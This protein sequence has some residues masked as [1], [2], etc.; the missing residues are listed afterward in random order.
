MRVNQIPIQM[1]CLVIRDDIHEIQRLE[2]SISDSSQSEWSKNI[3]GMASIEDDNLKINAENKNKVGDNLFYI[4]SMD[5]GGRSTI[6]VFQVKI[7]NVND[8][9][10]VVREDAMITGNQQWKEIIELEESGE[11]LYFDPSSIFSDEDPDDRMS[12]QLTST[13][14]N[15]INLTDDGILEGV[16][17]N[18]DVG[19]H[20]LTWRAT[21]KFGKSAY[22][23]LQLNVANINRS[24]RNTEHI[25]EIISTEDDYT[26]VDLNQLFFDED[27]IHG[28]S[29]DYLLRVYDSDKKKLITPEWMKINYS[30]NKMPIVNNKL[31]IEPTIYHIGE[32]GK[33]GEKLNVNKLGDLEKDT[34]LRVIVRATDQRVIERKGIVGIDLD[35]SWDT[36]LEIVKKSTIISNGLPLFNSVVEN[37]NGMR[38]NALHRCVEYWCGNWYIDNEEILTFDVKLKDPNQSINITLTPG[39]EP[40]T[41]FSTGIPPN[42]MKKVAIYINTQQGRVHSW[43][44]YAAQ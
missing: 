4:R 18:S 24:P 3:K 19:T 20:L 34:N 12:I 6:K 9:P 40:K 43:I 35:V 44:F 32:D 30:L 42:L 8:P 31:I 21:D 17:T 7:L 22:Y 5:Q 29:L 14:P 39:K 36:N 26:K 27:R 33:T 11:K 1:D 10:K 16:P 2:F 38:V 13:I 37:Q 41:E 28:D 15:W 25:N 23:S